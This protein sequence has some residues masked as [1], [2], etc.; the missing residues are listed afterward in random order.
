ML[1]LKEGGGCLLVG[2]H[3]CCFGSFH[4]F[5]NRKKKIAELSQK[6]LIGCLN[7]CC[8]VTVTWNTLLCLLA[9]WGDNTGDATSAL[10][11][12]CLFFSPWTVISCHSPWFSLAHT[13]GLLTSNLFPTS[14]SA[15]SLH[16]ASPLPCQSQG[17][18]RGQSWIGLDRMAVCQRGGPI[19]RSAVARI[20]PLSSASWGSPAHC[21]RVHWPVVTPANLHKEEK[22]VGGLERL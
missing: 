2:K 5:V 20:A 3:I 10:V 1:V 14:A 4:G 19:P 18:H 17:S 16:D 21:G 8:A 9:K 15:Q 22:R 7:D 11:S 13:T 12:F 6:R